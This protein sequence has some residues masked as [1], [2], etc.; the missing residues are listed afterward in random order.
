LVNIRVGGI[1]ARLPRLA[2]R[3]ERAAAWMLNHHAA[4]L[5]GLATLWGLQHVRIRTADDFDLLPDEHAEPLLV[6]ILPDP[7]QT[8]SFWQAWDRLGAEP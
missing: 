4:D 5:A 1:L 2:T 6:E 3:G 7:G 8:E